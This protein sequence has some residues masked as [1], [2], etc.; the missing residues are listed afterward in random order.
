MVESRKTLWR[1][2]F[3]S[4]GSIFLAEMGD[5]TQLAT[6]LLTV[7]SGHPLSTFAGAALAL[8]LT[9]FIGVWAGQWLSEKLPPHL[10]KITAGVGFLVMG[11]VMLVGSWGR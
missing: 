7:Q 9:S 8:L 3:I 10:I 2:G 11:A 4:F 6:M 1:L 5:K